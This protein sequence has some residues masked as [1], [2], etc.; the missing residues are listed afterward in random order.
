MFSCAQL[1]YWFIDQGAEAL[2][3]PHCL[4]LFKALAENTLQIPCFLIG[5]LTLQWAYYTNMP[6]LL[7]VLERR[8]CE[9]IP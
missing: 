5:I 8:S 3:Q 4:L 7:M 1:G 9:M 2:S 6:R